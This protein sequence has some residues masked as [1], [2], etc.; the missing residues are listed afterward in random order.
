MV[1][2]PFRRAGEQ[3]SQVNS[4]KNQI[5]AQRMAEQQLLTNDERNLI[6][7]REDRRQN[8]IRQQLLGLQSQEQRQIFGRDNILTGKNTFNQPSNLLHGNNILQG[9]STLLRNSES[10]FFGRRRN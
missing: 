9:R 4:I 3:R 6:R 2:N 10:L 5:Q 1:F 8:I 7:I